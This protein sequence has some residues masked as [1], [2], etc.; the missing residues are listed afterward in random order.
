MQE[1]REVKQKLEDLN[2]RPTIRVTINT[3]GGTY[4]S[5]NLQVGGDLVNGNKLL[6]TSF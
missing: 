1:L 4:I 5:G 2:N 3:G 6:H